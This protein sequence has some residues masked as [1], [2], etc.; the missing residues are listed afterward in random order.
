MKFRVRAR[1][2]VSVGCW[3]WCQGGHVE[4]RVKIKVEIKIEVEFQVTF[5]RGVEVKESDEA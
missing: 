1:H 2:E 5:K 4:V 3:G